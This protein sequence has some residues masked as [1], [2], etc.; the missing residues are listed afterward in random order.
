MLEKRNQAESKSPSVSWSKEYELATYNRFALISY[1]SI[2]SALF[3]LQTME[4]TS[5]KRTVIFY[6]IS[7]LLQWL[8]L[9]AGCSFFFKKDKSY[10]YIMDVLGLGFAAFYSFEL[11]T[12]INQMAFFY[13]IPLL[14]IAM[15]Y[16]NERFSIIC[17]SGVLVVN[18]IHEGIHYIADDYTVEEVKSGVLK[19]VI[20]F[21][22]NVVIVVSSRLMIKMNEMKLAMITREKELSESRSQTIIDVTEKMTEEIHQVVEVMEH[23]GDAVNETKLSMNHVSDGTNMTVESVAVQ[24]EKTEAIRNQ[25]IELDSVTNDLNENMQDTLQEVT[26]GRENISELIAHVNE[27]KA[28][29]SEVS[30]EITNLTSHMSNLESIV[31]IINKIAKQ[32]SLLALNA[33]IE[34]ARA[35]EAGKGFAVVASEISELSNQTQGATVNI[36]NLIQNISNE[37]NSVVGVVNQLINIGEVQNSKAEKTADSMEVIVSQI[38]KVHTYADSLKQV[39]ELIEKS[40]SSIMESVANITEITSTVSDKTNETYQISEKSYEV[41]N[42][43]IEYVDMLN[44]RALELRELT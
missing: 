37:L 41:V 16:C 36:S 32:T 23:L 25:I 20:L 3:V 43:V 29:S 40:N 19:L 22:V 27:S 21:F 44:Q 8:P 9:I 11:F 38:D 35:G 33:S 42:E 5:G 24:K 34:A 1:A 17:S 2:T 39:V 7:S 28:A 10:S 13:V 30:Y 4:L 18:M 12:D 15:C 31:E 6:I 14:I 26:K